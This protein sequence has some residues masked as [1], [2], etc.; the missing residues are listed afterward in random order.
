[1]PAAQP[2][3][4]I[5][6]IL[7]SRAYHHFVGPSGSGK[8]SWNFQHF[9][10][11]WAA[12]R[13]V[14][15]HASH[16]VPFCYVSL[17][18]SSEQ[19]LRT[20]ARLG[21][22]DLIRP[23]LFSAVDKKE[24]WNDFDLLVSFIHKKLPDIQLFILDF[25]VT[26]VPDMKINDAGAV[27]KLLHRMNWY[28]K[29]KDVTVLGVGG[30]A[31]TVNSDKFVPYRQR[32]AGSHLWGH[33]C[34]TILVLERENEQDENN[35]RRRLIICPRNATEEVHWY[36]QLDGRL[37]KIQDPCEAG[38]DPLDVRLGAIPIGSTIATSTM[39]SWSED[40]GLSESTFFRWL[41]RQKDEGRLISAGSK[42]S[43][44]KSAPY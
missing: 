17:D 42:G 40:A 35:H 30:D 33:C 37:T 21:V 7:P 8:T 6:E 1:M 34:S 20:A 14:L 4:L 39:R 43:W 3:F 15:G 16:P 22:E 23:R 32:P 28:A 18:H 11:E 13:P 44:Q 10:P 29:H 27:R 12:G 38:T 24:D 26:L 25:V 5:D 31:K 19:V 2:T 41:R 36:D 9:L